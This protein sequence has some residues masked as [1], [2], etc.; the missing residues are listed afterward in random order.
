MSSEV[1]MMRPLLSYDDI[2]VFSRF[3]WR[4][5]HMRERRLDEWTRAM[6]SSSRMI[7][8]ERVGLWSMVDDVLFRYHSPKNRYGSDVGAVVPRTEITGQ[9]PA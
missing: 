2:V 6:C 8:A 4:F 5:C 9:K 3:R 7:G 1:F